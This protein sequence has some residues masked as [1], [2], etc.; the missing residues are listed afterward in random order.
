MVGAYRAL[1]SGGGFAP[2]HVEPRASGA[3]QRVFTPEAAFL[4]GDVL[5]D[6]ASRAP[7]FGLENPL[8]TRVWS[9]AKT[10]TSK[11]MRDNWCVGFTARFTVG[12]W[13]GNFSGDSMWSVSGV[14]GA[15]PAWL[16]IVTHCRG[17]RRSTAAPAGLVRT[18]RGFSPDGARCLARCCAGAPVPHRRAGSAVLVLDPDIPDAR[19]CG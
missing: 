1:A 10:G 17:R 9:A 12:V 4:V 16:A 11:D 5:A 13:V 19:G 2:L 15:A 6:R 7:T 18:K 8:A 3:A 14:D